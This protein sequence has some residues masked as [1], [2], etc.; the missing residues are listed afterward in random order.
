VK[1]KNYKQIVTFFGL[2]FSG[3]KDLIMLLIYSLAF[4]PKGLFLL[5]D[6]PLAHMGKSKGG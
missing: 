4:Y 1:A 6:V 5:A 3:R 2:L